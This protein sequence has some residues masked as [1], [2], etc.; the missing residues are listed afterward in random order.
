MVHQWSMCIYVRILC[1][2]RYCTDATLCSCADFKESLIAALAEG[3]VDVEI[4]KCVTL[5]PPEAGKTQLKSALV[6]RFDDSEESTAMS[7]GAEV[8]MQR[9]ISGSAVWEP[10]TK[11][12][13][14]NSLRTT[15]ERKEFG[16]SASATS[17]PTA[18]NDA[19]MSAPV[20]DQKAQSLPEG[21]RMVSGKE[22]ATARGDEAK[23]IKELQK[24]F[25]EI[26]LSV[27]QGL[28][29][30]DSAEV[31]GLQKVR[32]IH[33][34][35]SGGQPAFFDIHPII[36]TSRAVYLLV[37]N[38]EKGLE[39]KPKITYRKK[40]VDFP[41][42]GMPNTMQ[43]NLDMITGSLLTLQHCKRKFV[44][45]E[46]ELH[47]WFEESISQSEDA[48][49][50]L[51]V[52]T[53]KKEGNIALENEKLMA[54]CSHLPSWK[55]VLPCTLTGTRLFPV[56]SIDPNCD[57][58]QVLRD[59][60]TEAE[61]TYQLRL[62][63]SWLFC[64]LIFWSAAENLQ[65]LPFSSLSDLCQHEGLVSDDRECLAMIRTFHLLGIFSFPYFDQE[66]TLGNQ[67]KP[68][69][70]PVFTNPDVLYQ[71]V[72]KILEVAFRQLEVTTMKP[73]KRR[74]LE[75]LQSNGRLNV[76][77]L[78]HLSI[79]DQLG[80]Y[81]GFHSFLMEQLV[82][83]R[84][85][86]RLASKVSADSIRGEV[87]YFIPSAFPPCNEKPFC[88]PAKGPIPGL[89]FT[90]KD[91]L[92]NKLPQYS[93]PLGIFPHLIVN[94]LTADKGYDIQYNT[95]TYKCLFRDAAIFVI[96][97][98]SSPTV[99]HSYNVRVTDNMSHISILIRP[100]H[101]ALIRSERDCH[102]IIRDFQ[103]ATEDAYER[104]YHTRHRSHLHA[105]VHVTASQRPTW[106]PSCHM[107]A[108]LPSTF[109]SASQQRVLTGCRTVQKISLLS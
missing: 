108:H 97:P 34:V 85:A 56:D 73:A 47:R 60:I 59:A 57:G 70:Q 19:S 89:A 84:L 102:R 76:G 20:V 28:K 68:D 91:A 55:E 90:F 10:L 107:L 49:P 78:Y 72:T 48:V 86:A 32:M 54:S 39:A 62:P 7:T 16:E 38:M 9:Y 8:V 109:K 75:E 44:K 6:G 15:V 31:K 66:Q 101:T 94:I 13:L 69:S 63:I 27:E 65:T 1:H 71:Q 95:D 21:Q 2:F 81:I 18:K 106:Q 51:I 61:C 96:K 30:A 87:E 45:L 92:G 79:P 43:S 64:Q 77:T 17:F 74:S 36:A 83:W 98:S 42:K 14:L 52:G 93:V 100:S 41:I 5:G 58:V 103:S 24:Q 12:R 33:L 22:A 40:D 82:H 46:R 29:E 88:F 11:E 104:I 4:V 26:R 3:S 67:W 53:R 37:Y 99:E 80:S 105:L 23:R 25:S 35:D 50:V